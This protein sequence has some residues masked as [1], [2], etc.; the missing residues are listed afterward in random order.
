MAKAVRFDRYGGSD[1][2]YVAADYRAEL[3]KQPEPTTEFEM[4]DGASITLGRERF[5]ATEIMFDST[6]LHTE[7]P[8]MSEFVSGA[9]KA[10]GIDVR[11]QLLSNKTAGDS[12][13]AN[14]TVEPAVCL[15]T[16]VAMLNADKCDS[17]S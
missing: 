12:F 2:L 10:C 14:H 13:L 3:A 9:V 7:Q 1:V 6:I 5:R 17:P 8:T 11:R 15:S 16:C 4:P